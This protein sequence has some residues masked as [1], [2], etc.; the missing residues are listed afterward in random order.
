M[1]Y[2]KQGPFATGGTATAPNL[3]AMDNGIFASV[4]QDGSTP[5]TGQ[6]TVV[7][8]DKLA[9]GV[10]ETNGTGMQTFT[11]TAS[12][13]FAIYTRFRNQ[14]T[15]TPTSIT[16][17]GDIGVVNA[18]NV[19]TTFLTR[20]G[21]L[22]QWECS[23]SGQTTWLGHYTTVGNCLLAVDLG[24]NT[25]DQH[26]EQCGNVHTGVSI[27]ALFAATNYGGIAGAQALSFTCPDCGANELYDARVT[28]A[29][30]S[31][32]TPQGAGAFATT[33]GA[34]ATMIRQLLSLLSM[35][36]AD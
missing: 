1:T 12:Q 24:A 31:D 18:I 36:I 19:V 10:Q 2:T 30:E 26:C 11:P 20:D 14:M 17:N 23:T 3:T 21:F 8:P 13:F 16:L 9:S 6:Q 27:T 5:M 15:N 7:A 35:P 34:Q 22:L 33:R 29:D 28:G 32:P 4:Q 25:F